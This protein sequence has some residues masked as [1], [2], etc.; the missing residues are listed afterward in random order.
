MQFLR[1]V[2]GSE[3]LPLE[4]QI[5]CDLGGDDLM[6]IPFNSYGWKFKCI[7]PSEPSS[8]NSNDGVKFM[9][10]YNNQTNMILTAKIA[11]QEHKYNLTVSW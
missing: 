3:N 7:I 2:M 6:W 11:H 5:I 10:G 1:I 8:K 9:Y 4:D